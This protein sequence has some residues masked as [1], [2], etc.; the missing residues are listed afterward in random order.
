[1]QAAVQA[2]RND[3]LWL[4]EAS[5]L[6][7]A[8]QRAAERLRKKGIGALMPDPTDRA[9]P[10]RAA[11][12]DRASS[13]SS[14]RA[15]SQPTP[16]AHHDHDHQRKLDN[17]ELNAILAYSRVSA[18]S[19]R[20]LATFLEYGPRPVRARA[21][22]ELARLGGEQPQWAKLESLAREA[23]LIE[24]DPELKG[25]LAKLVTSLENAGR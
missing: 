6:S 20:Q 18:L 22:A 2:G 10:K 3:A 4:R 21:V 24:R 9:E 14:S 25:E 16:S 23:H 7:L 13:S 17:P 1:M 12:S 19:L 15:A 5:E 8:A 11:Q